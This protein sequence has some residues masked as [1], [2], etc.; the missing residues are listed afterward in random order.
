MVGAGILIQT[1]KVGRKRI[2]AYEDYLEIPEKEPEI[3]AVTVWI[4]R[5]KN[6]N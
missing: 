6:K 2:F 3:T 4:F 1:S 5:V